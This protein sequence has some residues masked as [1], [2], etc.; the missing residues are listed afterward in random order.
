MGSQHELASYI[1][2][3]RA[4]RPN[5]Q[6]AR[7]YEYC[8]LRVIHAW[9]THDCKTIIVT[10][11]WN[12]ITEQGILA[13]WQL[14]ESHGVRLSPLA[15]AATTGLLYQ[16]QMIDDGECVAIGGMKISR[17]NRSTRRKPAPMPL[18]PP[19]IPHDLTW[20]GSRAAAVGSRRV[21]AWAMARPWQLNESI[22]ICMTHQF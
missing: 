19:Q 20:A 18:C 13:H 8:V 7:L 22:W 4:A 15:T 21:T 12:Y 6:T 3:I 14:N 2:V 16:P 1:C 9:G 10:S 5:S 17:G 11:I